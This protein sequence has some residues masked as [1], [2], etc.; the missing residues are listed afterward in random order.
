[1]PLVGC[2]VVE[3][4]ARA[5]P[6]LRKVKEAY[7]SLC[8]LDDVLATQDSQDDSDEDEEAADSLERALRQTTMP[9]SP[10]LA[11]SEGRL[12]EYLRKKAGGGRCVAG[13]RVKGLGSECSI[14]LPCLPCFDDADFWPRIFF[15]AM[16][17]GA[18]EL[19][20]LSHDSIMLLVNSACGSVPAQHKLLYLCLCKTRELYNH[21]KGLISLEVKTRLKM[22]ACNGKVGPH[23]VRESGLG[24][25]GGG[26]ILSC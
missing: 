6:P 23:S 25:M 14:R 9:T 26:S 12:C 18:H 7:A 4:A 16:A 22:A 3:A 20:R 2:S 5:K 13:G 11:R 24:H 1:M 21:G 17:V 10:T 8:L 15:L 19:R